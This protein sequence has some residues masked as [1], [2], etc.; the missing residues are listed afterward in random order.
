MSSAILCMNMGWNTAQVKRSPAERE[1][2]QR[3]V[4]VLSS[5]AT[6]TATITNAFAS[7]PINTAMPLIQSRKVVDDSERPYSDFGIK[8]VL[9]IAKSVVS[10][11]VNETCPD[12]RVFSLLHTLFT[13]FYC[14]EQSSCL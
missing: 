13:S 8:V 5:T 9:F 3:F 6:N 12:V 1:P 7:V 11:V 10:G 14:T 2:R 4:A